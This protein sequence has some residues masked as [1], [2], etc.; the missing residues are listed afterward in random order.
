MRLFGTVLAYSI[1]EE[2]IPKVSTYPPVQ[3]NFLVKPPANERADLKVTEM[4]MERILCEMSLTVMGQANM[5]CLLL[6]GESETV[7]HHPLISH[8]AASLQSIC[9]VEDVQEQSSGCAVC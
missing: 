9:E 3:R 7:V 6:S 1:K 5:N 2:F 8:R 4:E